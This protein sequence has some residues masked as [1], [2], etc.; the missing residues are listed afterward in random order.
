MLGDENWSTGGDEKKLG[1]EGRKGTIKI[2][3]EWKAMG[4]GRT[5]TKKLERTG[6]GVGGGVMDADSVGGI[7]TGNK[8]RTGH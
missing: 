3:T 5:A 1:K 7:K 4:N 8:K 2:E 6:G